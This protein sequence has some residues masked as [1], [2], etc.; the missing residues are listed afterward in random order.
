LNFLLITMLLDRQDISGPDQIGVP[1][2]ELDKLAHKMASQPERSGRDF[3]RRRGPSSSRG[4]SR[5][6]PSSSAPF[7]RK[8]AGSS[9]GRGFGA[10]AGERAPR[11]AYSGPRK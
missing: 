11:G 9:E 5:G 7:K 3:K 4:P 6:G 1:A 2:N 10:G 8:P